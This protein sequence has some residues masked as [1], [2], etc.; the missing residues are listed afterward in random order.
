MSLELNFQNQNKVTV[1]EQRCLSGMNGVSNTLKIC[2]EN[3][4]GLIHDTLQCGL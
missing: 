2:I 1:V 4:L 3:K